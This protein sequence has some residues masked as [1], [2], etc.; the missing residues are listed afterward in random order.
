[1]LFH[2]MKKDFILAKKY[3]IVM[4]I[5]AIVFPVY[6]NF[7]PDIP[8]KGFLSFFLSTLY[9]QYLMFN[10]VSMIEY[11]YKGSMLLCTT[12]Y[13]RKAMVMSKYLFILTL[14]AGCYLI[15]TSLSLILP[16]IIDRLELFQ[17]GLS[18]FISTLVFGVVIPVQYYFGYE[19]SK[20]IFMIIIFILPFISPLV[21]KSIQ[22]N[23]NGFP[24]LFPLSPIVFGFVL[25]LFILLIG[26]LSIYLS[27]KIYSKQNL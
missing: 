20:Y 23:Q 7:N 16:N 22:T 10:A 14:F 21:I 24:T 8:M 12:P 18:F 15:N 5:F 6:I 3:W 26:W 17:V 4:I 25:S 2:L 1:M 19:K 27:I 13:T 9:I 11:K